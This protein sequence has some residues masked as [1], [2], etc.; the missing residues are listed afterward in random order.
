[1]PRGRQARPVPGWWGEIRDGFL[2]S[3]RRRN[4]RPNTEKS[5]RYEL[6]T[7]GAW[8]A[9]QGINSL[10][11][12][13]PA[14]LEAWQ[15]LML[16]RR[17]APRSQIVKISALRGCLKWAALQELPLSKPTLWLR[18]ESPR[19]PALDP[20]PIPRRE[21]EAIL[22]HL[23]E[24]GP[25]EI[26]HRRTR[27][28]FWALFTS[29]ARISEVLSLRRGEVDTEEGNHVIQKGGRPHVLL[30]GAKALAAIDD[31]EAMREDNCPMMFAALFPQHRGQPL[32]HRKHEIQVC[33][34]RLSR[35]AGVGRFTS[36][37]IRHSCATT[38]RRKR[39]DVVTIGR[40]MGWRGLGMIYNYSL[41][42]VED[43]L[44]AVALLDSVGRQQQ[45]NIAVIG[46]A[47]AS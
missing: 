26:W 44:E 34:D 25:D 47:I 20:R 11:E 2:R 24:P 46:A 9:E 5:Y 30:M 12:L 32:L 41:V 13:Q 17:A 40:H 45:P 27:A 28:L 33:W 42:D 10:P 35:E 18:L 15:D 43:R 39:V 31:Y 38:L 36:H 7:F 19:V 21:L 37:R 16:E 1:M 14:H 4:R 22:R 3:L 29:G 6:G 23:D 8:L